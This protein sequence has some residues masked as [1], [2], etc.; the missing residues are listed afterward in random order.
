[1]CWIYIQNGCFDEGFNLQMEIKQLRT[2]N[3]TLGSPLRVTLGCI[4]VSEKLKFKL[5]DNMVTVLH[6]HGSNMQASLRIFHD[7]S[8]WASVN[9]AA[10]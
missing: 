9:C 3:I 6:D 5:Y 2:T 7:D 10:H 4:Y 8:R 1:M